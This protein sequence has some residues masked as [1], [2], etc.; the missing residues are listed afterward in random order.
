MDF[1]LTEEQR[2]IADSATQLGERFGLEYWRDL[3]A[4]KAYPHECWRAICEAGLCGVALP[5]EYGGSELGVFEMALI[6]ERLAAT[7]A[8]STEIGRAHVCTP[9]TNA[10]TVCR[11]LIE[12]K[13]NNK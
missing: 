10:H 5:S 3:D 13:K 7:G 1:Q 6:I 2:M 12:K 8:G 9:V 11:I 4:R